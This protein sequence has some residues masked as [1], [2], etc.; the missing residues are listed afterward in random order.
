[1]KRILAL[2]LMLSMI[3]ALGACGNAA[4]SAAPAESAAVSEAAPV[5]EAPVEEAP[6]EEAA[7]DAVEEKVGRDER[8]AKI[9]ALEGIVADLQAQINTINE[10]MAEMQAFIDTLKV[11]E[12]P[13]VEETVLRSQKVKSDNPALKFFRK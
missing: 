6:A 1:M 7:E 10:K 13:A 12:A 8:D 3:F 4:E 11:V 9:D 5:E 2:L